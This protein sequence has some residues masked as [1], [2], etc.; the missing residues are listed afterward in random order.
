MEELKKCHLS[1][2][3]A[4]V[5]VEEGHQDQKGEEEQV[6]CQTGNRHLVQVVE[7]EVVARE[8]LVRIQLWLCAR[9][10]YL[11]HRLTAAATVEQLVRILAFQRQ[12][13]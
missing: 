3:V 11:R 8:E 13:Q 10:L 2:V 6:A 4:G 1:L 12:V 9:L 5:V 7:A